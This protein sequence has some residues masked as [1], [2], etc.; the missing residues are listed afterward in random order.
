MGVNVAKI[1]L[2][3]RLRHI[4]EEGSSQCRAAHTF[5]KKKKIK[6]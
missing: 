1:A 2:E 4:V 6:I 3:N 5:K